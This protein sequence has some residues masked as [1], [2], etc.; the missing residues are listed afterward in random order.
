MEADEHLIDL[1]RSYPCLYDVRSADFK[2]ALKKENA[3]KT[4]AE[5]L[6]KT[7]IVNTDRYI[8]NLIS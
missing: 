7:G 4:I 8:Y 3:W 5:S 6:E 2:I 1:V